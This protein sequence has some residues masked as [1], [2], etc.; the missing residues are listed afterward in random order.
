MQLPLSVVTILASGGLSAVTGYLTSRLSLQR[1]RSINRYTFHLAILAEVRGLHSRLLEYEAA[2]V[3]RVMT[4]QVSGAQVLTVLLQPADTVVFNNNALSIG[5]FDRR[6]ALRVLRFYADIRTLQG[7]ADVLSQVAD[8]AKSELL[9]SEMQRHLL[10]VRQVRRR[11]HSLIKRLRRS[12]TG[13]FAG[14]RWM[15]RRAPA[16]VHP[17]APAPP[18]QIAFAAPPLGG[19]RRPGRERK[20]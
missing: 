12:P 11:A 17:P 18:P 16:T 15:R 2:F 20:L 5:L 14:S 6:T 13:I 9:Q 10:L 3:N 1:Q 7:R 19:W 8:V 4:G